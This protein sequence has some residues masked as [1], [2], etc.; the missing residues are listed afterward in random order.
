MLPLESDKLNQAIKIIIKSFLR[1]ADVEFEDSLQ[2]INRRYLCFQEEV[3]LTHRQNLE[4]HLVKQ[5]TADV[6]VFEAL[7]K[8]KRNIVG[9]SGNGMWPAS[10]PAL[11]M[12]SLSK[13]SNTSTAPKTVQSILAW[14]EW[15][16]YDEPLRRTKTTRT[17]GTGAWL[18]ESPEFRYWLENH[19][20]DFCSRTLWIHGAPGVGKSVICGTAVE[21]L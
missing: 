21:Y 11:K 3:T 13:E 5:N 19:D 15:F 10:F 6:A 12:R 14:L 20:Q 7:C 1:S 8:N 4:N 2:S 17:S 18:V 16:D 9:D